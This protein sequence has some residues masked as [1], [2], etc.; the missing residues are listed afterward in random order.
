MCPMCECTITEEPPRV[1]P[2]CGWELFQLD[3][4]DPW[5]T[6]VRLDIVPRLGE[7]VGQTP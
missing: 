5:V 4:S 3:E 1:C 2:R 6:S 7:S